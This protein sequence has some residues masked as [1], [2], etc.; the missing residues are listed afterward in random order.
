MDGNVPCAL[1]YGVY[2]Y[3]L[4]QFARVSSH[5]ADFNAHNKTLTT[6]LLQQ[7]YCY[8]KLKKAFSKF[9]HQ[10][11]KLVFKYSTRLKTL[12]QQGLLVSEFYG[13]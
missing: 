7:G 12:L 8:H 11:Y 13:D 6:K 1:S 9:D 2:T 5:L 4:I 10:Q 3:Q